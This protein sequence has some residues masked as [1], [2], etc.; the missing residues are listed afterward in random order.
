LAELTAVDAEYLAIVDPISFA[1][2]STITAPALVA[3][4]ANVG[5]VRLIDNVILEPV[6]APV[7]T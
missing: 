1:P 7:A 4:A 2:L 5:P 6:P 3:V